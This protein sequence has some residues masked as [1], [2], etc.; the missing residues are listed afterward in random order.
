MKLICKN[1]NNLITLF[2]V[3]FNKSQNIFLY[4]TMWILN[5]LHYVTLKLL[6]LFV[7]YL[8]KI[9]SQFN[10]IYCLPFKYWLYFIASL[11]INYIIIIINLYW[12]VSCLFSIFPWCLV[13]VSVNKKI[14]TKEMFKSA[15]RVV[16]RNGYQYLGRCLCFES[17]II[18]DL[19]DSFRMDQSFI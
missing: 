7:I 5:T 13:N 17:I 16:L 19:V 6:I 9:I 18:N 11:I 2:N 12:F 14:C 3:I 1:I 10:V 8:D 15:E 4:Y